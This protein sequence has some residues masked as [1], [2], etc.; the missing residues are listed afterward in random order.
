MEGTR[1][2]LLSLVVVVVVTTLCRPAPY[3]IAGALLSV[4][5]RRSGNGLRV[6]SN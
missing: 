2:K 1:V 5:G 4:M 6:P 3:L